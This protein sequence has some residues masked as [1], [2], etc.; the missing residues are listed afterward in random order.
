MEA[1]FGLWT[2]SNFH[3]ST[4]E[5]GL[6]FL[7]VGGAGLLVQ[8][9]CIGPLVSRFGEARVIV[10]GLFILALAILLPPLLR[11]PAASVVLMAMLMVGHS[12]AFPN[13]GALVSR[14]TPRDRQGSVMD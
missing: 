9:F 5:V 3:W 4:H 7:A 14:T 1:V 6:T 2:A 13:A 10:G 12:L 8:A 11:L